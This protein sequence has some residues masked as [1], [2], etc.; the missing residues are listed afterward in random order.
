MPHSFNI[1][2]VAE[3]SRMAATAAASPTS[4]SPVSAEKHSEIFKMFMKKGYS[5]P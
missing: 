4:A 5:M 3:A 2:V 1:F